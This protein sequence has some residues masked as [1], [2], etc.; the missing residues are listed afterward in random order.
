MEVFPIS[1][2][3]FVLLTFSHFFFDKNE[4]SKVALIGTSLIAKDGKQ[5]F[6]YFLATFISSFENAVQTCSPH[7]EWVVCFVF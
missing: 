4:F 1:F 7:S 2:T 3:A 6:S 5:F